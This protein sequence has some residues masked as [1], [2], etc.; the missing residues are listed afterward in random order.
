MKLNPLEIQNYLNTRLIGNSII[1][2]YEVPSTNEVALE[3]ASKGALEGT[4]VL[5]ES[6]TRGRGRMGRSWYSPPGEGIY[7]SVIL[8]PPLP[9]QKAYQITFMAAVA[10][11]ETL[12]HLSGLDV[13]IKW[14]NDLMIRNK[15]VGG[16]LTELKAGP[17]RIHWVVTGIGINAN[18]VQF[19]QELQDQ[20][21][22]LMLESGY[23]V[24]R[25]P[26]IQRLLRNF[27]KWYFLILEGNFPKLFE[28]WCSLSC[29][30]GNQVEIKIGEEI[31]RG[32]AT[33]V[34]QDGTLYVR[35][36][37]G[38]ERP[39]VTGDVALVAQK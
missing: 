7:I 33:R 24:R 1:W 20:V 15:K 38:Q 32:L 18:I 6:Q 23:P 12:R 16:I 31:I 8:K 14:P 11:A 25:I 13:Q 19:P 39:I 22:S 10:A 26:L 2:E 29:T 27:E 4:V 5:A 36:D 3:L 30:L 37:S 9:P 35:E 34:E 28:T 21:T 17:D